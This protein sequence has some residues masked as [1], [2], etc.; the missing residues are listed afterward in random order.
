ML[1][2]YGVEE[3]QLINNCHKQL[4]GHALYAWYIIIIT[5]IEPN[6]FDNLLETRE[7]DDPLYE[8]YYK[9]LLVSLY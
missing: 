2:G 8:V 1:R 7:S 3:A 6:S 9:T 4:S 5:N